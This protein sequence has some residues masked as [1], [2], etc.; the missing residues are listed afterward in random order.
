V[1]PVKLQ[2]NAYSFLSDRRTLNKLLTFLQH[3]RDG[4]TTEKIKLTFKIKPTLALGNKQVNYPGYI[5]IDKEVDGDF[6]AKQGIRL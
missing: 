1:V 4:Q 6:L 2:A 5:T 3:V